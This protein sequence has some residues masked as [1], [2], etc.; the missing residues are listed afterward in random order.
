M[1]EMQQTMS[2]MSA[3]LQMRLLALG[4]WQTAQQMLPS[5]TIRLQL[6]ET[7]LPV[8]MQQTMSS[9]SEIGSKIPR[10]S[11]TSSRIC[12]EP[13]GVDLGQSQPRHVVRNT[14]GLWI[15]IGNA[16]GLHT[17]C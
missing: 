16:I 9:M 1:G 11:W 7:S 2:S 5:L 17:E 13:A 6:A 8:E 10:T 12:S 14:A 4:T 15:A 3:M